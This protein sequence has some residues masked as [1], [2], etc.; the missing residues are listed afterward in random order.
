MNSQEAKNRIEEL[1]QKI[2]YYNDKYYQEHI[3]EISDYDFDILLEELVRLEGQFPEYK[4]PD[5]PTLRVGGGITKEFASVKHK[6][7]M[8]SLGNTY[9]EQEVR[10]FDE[11][12][13]KFLNTQDDI[14]YVCEMKFDGVSMSLTYENGILKQAV[15]RGDSVQG[16]DVTTNIKTIKTIPL[17]LKSG[18]YPTNFEVRGEVFMSKQNF[19]KLNKDREDIGETLYAN[20]RNTASGTVKLQ[21]SAE[22]ARRGLDCFLYFLLG[23]NLP[24]PSHSEALEALS[25]WGFQVSDTYKKCK[26]IEEVL[27]YIKAWEQKRHTLPVETDGAVIKV[28]NFSKQEELGLT[29]KSPRWA[30]A[31]KYKAE[32]VGTL[33]QEITYQVGRTGAVTP[34]AEL[35]PVQLAG[36]TVKRASLHNANEIERLGL[37]IGD[38]VFVE[39]GG[40]IIPK[41]TGVDLTKRPVSSIPLIYIQNCPE[42]N[43]TLV[44]KEGEALH[45]CPNEKGCP[46]QIK[47][48]IEHFV[49]RKAM[50][51]SSLGEKIIEQLYNAGLIKNF[52]DLYDLKQNQLEA[53]DRMGEKSATKIIK[54]VE[55]SKMIPFER[56]LFALGIRF[57][58]ATVAKKLADYFENIDSLSQAT[59]E[60]LTQVPEI[61]DRIA[62]SVVEYFA[63]PDSQDIVK[64]LKASGLSLVTQKQAV[65]QKGTS[66]AGKTFV[67]SGV[68]SQFSREGIEGEIEAH[69]GKLLSGVSGKL[70]YLVA[71]DKMGPSKLEKAQ[72]LGIKI[73]SEEDFIKMIS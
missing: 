42:C 7:P 13:K 60:M 39:K 41:V 69:G 57:V 35:K 12:V 55:E 22:V 72:K 46:P 16:D 5:S 54:N 20:P 67:V 11:R 44:R 51:I 15:T 24:Y 40:E 48:K 31:F 1:S 47:G 4:T 21:D 18:D 9:S 70:D 17:K 29:A 23:E 10:D 66:L 8:L 28:N 62:Q 26:N 25:K 34:V 63:E 19:E 59:L 2:N 50:D 64:R 65:E 68:F 6:Y 38:T 33:L 30:I 27:E 53:L 3:S 32:S 73:I 43:T 71:G 36:T 61:G 56:V 37:R 49:Q 58:G 14:E 45:Y 52:A